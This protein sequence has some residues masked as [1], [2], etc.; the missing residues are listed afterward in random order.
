ME[1]SLYVKKVN[2]EVNG[3][4]IYDETFLSSKKRANGKQ[5]FIRA[6]YT[7]FSVEENTVLVCKSLQIRV[8]NI[9]SI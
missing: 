4:L 5:V 2:N 8:A 1:S 6:M 7:N 9:R 3:I